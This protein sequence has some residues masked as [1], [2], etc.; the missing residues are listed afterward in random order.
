MSNACNKFLTHVNIQSGLPLWNIESILF[1]S[2]PPKIV[3]FRRIHFIA[4]ASRRLKESY[5]VRVKRW[6]MVNTKQPICS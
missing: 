6:K 5:K 2:K 1:V 3:V 4:T